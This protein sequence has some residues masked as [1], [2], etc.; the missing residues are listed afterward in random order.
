MLDYYCLSNSAIFSLQLLFSPP[1][2]MQDSRASSISTLPTELIV[3]IFKNLE[4]LDSVIALSKSS[5]DF[6]KIA[7][8]HNESIIN[9]FLFQGNNL[10]RLLQ[11]DIDPFWAD[12]HQANRA[13]A[14]FD[15]KN[16]V[17]SF[18]IW[19]CGW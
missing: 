19:H 7:K 17:I 4:D 1:Q 18:P 11:P 8:R 3:L 10:T 5:G 2:Q 13:F 12:L 9:P 16:T 15:E 6:Y 14:F